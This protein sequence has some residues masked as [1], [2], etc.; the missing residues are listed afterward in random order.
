MKLAHSTAAHIH[1][2]ISWPL[3][4]CELTWPSWVNGDFDWLEKLAPVSVFNRFQSG[5][6][7][8]HSFLIKLTP[9][10]HSKDIP[11][12]TQ[13][14][15]ITFQHIQWPN[16]IVHIIKTIQAEHKIPFFVLK[17]TV[18]VGKWFRTNSVVPFSFDCEYERNVQHRWSHS[19]SFQNVWRIMVVCFREILYNTGYQ[20]TTPE[21]SDVFEFSVSVVCVVCVCYGMCCVGVNIVCKPHAEP[22]PKGTKGERN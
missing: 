9:P 5:F 1:T 12:T 8:L 21:A 4:E 14:N 6:N 22:S 18:F 3:G 7:S 20:N 2:H 19:W 16:V 11:R 15:N 10:N 17:W 13:V